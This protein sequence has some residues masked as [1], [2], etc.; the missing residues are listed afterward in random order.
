M[1]RC[2]MADEVVPE[3]ELTPPT[4]PVEPP[5]LLNQDTDPNLES[6]V[7]P[8]VD[9]ELVPPANVHPL[10]PGGRRFNQVYAQGKQAQRERDEERDRRVRAETE[11]EILKRGSVTTQKEYSLDE[12]EAMIATGSITRADAYR[13]R[14]EVVERRLASKLKDDFQK[15][16]STATRLATMSKTIYDYVQAVPDLSSVDTTIRQRV[17]SEF[18]YLVALQGKDHRQ[19]TDID[20]RAFELNALRNVLGPIET[21]TKRMTT[22]A[23]PHQGIPGGTRPTGKVNTDQAL[24]NKLTPREVKHYNRMFELGKYPGGWKDVV[25]ELKYAPPTRKS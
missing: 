21:L 12:L 8:E 10:A 20:R 22:N 24:L 2:Y 14:E 13:H 4:I 11:L 15:E 18:D 5:T 16:T 9:P 3:V 23:E 25:A 19:L 1:H 7:D 17:D 6:D